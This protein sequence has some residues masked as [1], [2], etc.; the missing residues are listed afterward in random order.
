MRRILITG[1][2]GFIGRN[3]KEYLG[4][5]FKV[6]AP[7]HEELDLLDGN[8]VRDYVKRNE[9]KLIIHG[10]NVG[11]GRDTQNQKDVIGTNLRIFFNIIRNENL[12][13]RIIYFG[14]GAEY[15]KSRDLKKV[16]EEDFDKRIPNDDYGFYKYVCSKYILNTVIPSGIPIIINWIFVWTNNLF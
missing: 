3:L 7:T 6:F 15:D 16:K 9:I 12:V 14:S 1:S 13:E 11:G 4:K 8:K 10:A 2:S 5:K